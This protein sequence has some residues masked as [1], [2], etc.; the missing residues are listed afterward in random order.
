M[1]RMKQSQNYQS[2]YAVFHLL[3]PFG[4]IHF[5]SDDR[6]SSILLGKLQKSP[7]TAYIS[8]FCSRDLLKMPSVEVPNSPFGRAVPVSMK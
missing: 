3:N 2:D 4:I 8:T 7:M 1:T 5:Y 6:F